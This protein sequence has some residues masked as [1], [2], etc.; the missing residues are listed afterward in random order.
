[1]KTFD[2]IKEELRLECETKLEKLSNLTIGTP[3][4]IN[5]MKIEVSGII[6]NIDEKTKDRIEN[7]I[8]H[9]ID[10]AQA[11]KTI[12]DIIKFNGLG[13]NNQDIEV[14]SVMTK[15]QTNYKNSYFE[16]ELRNAIEAQYKNQLVQ[17][18]TNEMRM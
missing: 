11:G 3:D 10:M 4:Y 7:K 9:V 16:N 5:Q 17:E 13:I 15:W 1:M 18:E 12:G 8:Q 14:M 2:E 6:N